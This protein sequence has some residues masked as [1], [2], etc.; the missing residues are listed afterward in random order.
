MKKLLTIFIWMMIGTGICVAQQDSAFTFQG[1]LNDGGIAANGNYDMAFR[2][3]D[4]LMGERRSVQP[5]L[6]IMLRLRTGFFRSNW[7]SPTVRL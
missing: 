1:K 7:I 2:I 4:A 5:L 6:C 3:Y